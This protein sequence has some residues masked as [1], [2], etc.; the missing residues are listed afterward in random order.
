M[1]PLIPIAWARENKVVF[2]FDTGKFILKDSPSHVYSAKS[3]RQ[4]NGQIGK[5]SYWLLPLTSRAFT[6]TQT[7]SIKDLPEGQKRAF[8]SVAEVKSYTQDDSAAPAAGLSDLDTPSFHSCEWSN[9][10]EWQLLYDYWMDLSTGLCI[11]SKT[12]VLTF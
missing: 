1:P 4:A 3:G 11:E 10:E 8:S 6:Q 9:D 7:G 12:M 2:D 5:K